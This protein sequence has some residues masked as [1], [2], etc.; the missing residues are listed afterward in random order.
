M[1]SAGGK[2][3]AV[4][5]DNKYFIVER[6]Q[7]TF[8]FNFH[9][10]VE[11]TNVVVGVKLPGKYIIALDSDG[12]DTGGQVFTSKNLFELVHSL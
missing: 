10:D 7:L 3:L 4:H 9:C 5:E 11:L 1:R 12:A 2:T 6:G 8:I